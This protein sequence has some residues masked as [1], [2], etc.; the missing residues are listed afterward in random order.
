MSIHEKV[1]LFGIGILVVQLTVLLLLMW[2]SKKT[3]LFL[4]YQL[5]LLFWLIVGISTTITHNPNI[6]AMAP[7]VTVLVFIRMFTNAIMYMGDPDKMKERW[8]FINDIER[9]NKE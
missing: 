1:M 6:V 2:R 7:V 9:K 3:Y 5:E 4:G 8:S